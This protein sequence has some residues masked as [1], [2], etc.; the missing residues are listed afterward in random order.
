MIA[1]T[2]FDVVNDFD[3]CA[4]KEAIRAIGNNSLA[5]AIYAYRQVFELEDRKNKDA[6][7]EELIA[8]QRLNAERW[9]VA[10]HWARQFPAPDWYR[11]MSFDEM[12]EFLLDKEQNNEEL[13]E[14]VSTAI[15]ISKDE[16]K[17]IDQVIAQQR[18]DIFASYRSAIDVAIRQAEV[19]GDDQPELPTRQQVALA[20]KVIASL[21][22]A[23]DRTIARI[24]RTRSTFLLGDIPLLD[25]A[26]KELEDWIN[27]VARLEE[28]E[29]PF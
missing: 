6:D 24:L 26:I 5:R 19:D 29:A 15:G 14:A 4:K 10:Y 16:V 7:D 23:K 21:K 28:E 13:I 20:E 11:V 25:H 9:A 2:I 17:K 12:F 27:S 8:K 1:K 22:K 18:R 3:D